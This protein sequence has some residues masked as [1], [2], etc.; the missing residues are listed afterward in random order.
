MVLG[1]W[2]DSPDSPAFLPSDAPDET[3]EAALAAQVLV[4]EYGAEA[5][6]A[7]NGGNIPATLEE[8]D[9]VRYALIA[10]EGE[11]AG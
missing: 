5:V 9:A 6:L 1:Q 11:A 10:A 2:V 3:A 4:E 8:I 7:A